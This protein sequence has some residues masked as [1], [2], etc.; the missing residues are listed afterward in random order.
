M[1]SIREPFVVTP[2][3]GAR[4]LTR[5]RLTAA[6]QAVVRAVGEYLGSLASADLSWRCRLGPTPDQR[7]ARKRTL[8]GQSSSRWAGSITRTSNDQ[9]QRGLANLADHRI[10]LRRASRAI[11]SRLAIPVGQRQGRVHG[12]GTRA[13]R[14]AKLGRLQHL[15]AELA[16]VEG[17][18][19]AGRVSVC[20]GGRRL[21][22]L[23]HAVVGDAAVG[24]HGG[25][26]GRG[27]DGSKTEVT[28]AEWHAR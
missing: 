16:E 6:D 17:R 7:A 24:D 19:A 20:R 26:R 15:Q 25:N 12:Y 27:K 3:A 2:P 14:F 22:K 4:I 13:E 18:L 1:R 28:E 8:T 9:W 21:A 23:R 5:L 11:R 10:A